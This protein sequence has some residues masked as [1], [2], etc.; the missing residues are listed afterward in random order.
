[1]YQGTL[2]HPN[3]SKAEYVGCSEP[4]F[5]LR[6]GN[7]KNSFSHY[8]YRSETTRFKYVWD[9]GLNPEPNIIW[10]FQKRCVYVA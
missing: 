6:Y 10:K 7:H 8:S 2:Q 4:S 5:K 9:Q 3:D 1:M